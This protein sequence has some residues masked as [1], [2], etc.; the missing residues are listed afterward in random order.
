LKILYKGASNDINRKRNDL[1]SPV[2]VRLTIGERHLY[3]KVVLQFFQPITQ[4]FFHKC[5]LFVTTHNC[6]VFQG[7]CNSLGTKISRRVME[8]LT[9]YAPIKK[10]KI[11]L[12]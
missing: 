4:L 9:K 10:P 6:N 11:D 7:I 1:K 2:K 5:A 12:G 3:K 8:Y